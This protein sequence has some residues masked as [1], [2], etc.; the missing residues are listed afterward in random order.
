MKLHPILRLK[1]RYLDF[2]HWYEWRQWEKKW[3]TTVNG[4]KNYANWPQCHHA[5][6]EWKNRVRRVKRIVELRKA[7]QS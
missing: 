5:T 4:V 2:V 3:V 1:A 7:I 6:P